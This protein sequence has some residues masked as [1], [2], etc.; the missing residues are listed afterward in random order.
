MRKKILSIVLAAAMA[1]S[2]ASCVKV[3]EPTIDSPSGGGAA[4]QE[5][6][7]NE[8]A[9]GLDDSA[10]QFLNSISIETAEAKGICGTDIQW[11]YQDN[12][13]VLKG[14]GATNDYGDEFDAK[15]NHAPWYDLRDKVHW[16]IIEPG[17]ERLGNASFSYMN[18]INK[19]TIPDTV[20]SIGRWS[21]IG[22][23][24]LKEINI[25]DGITTLECGLFKECSSLESFTM[26]NSVTVIEENAFRYCE[27]LKNITLSENLETIAGG[28]F[29]ECSSLTE[30]T[31]PKTVRMMAYDAFYW[32]IA[33]KKVIFEGN[34]PET[35]VSPILPETLA[36]ICNENDETSNITIE[37]H[38]NGYEPYIEQC[39]DYIWV[40]AS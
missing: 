19:V 22:C 31:I 2:L 33:L 13:L 23:T 17:I 12:V 16:V 5:T 30:I 4:Q 24:N 15:D 40:K 28:C 38:G 7:S 20:S 8:T 34:V 26:P 39:P 1:L 36:G 3:D 21:F 18:A 32:N 37:Y 14:S 35:E 27:K 11:Y 9:S 25:P 10:Q 6:V 29:N